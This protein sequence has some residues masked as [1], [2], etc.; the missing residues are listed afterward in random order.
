MVSDRASC[1]CLWPAESTYL[2]GFVCYQQRQVIPFPNAGMRDR[3]M[4]KPL[5]WDRIIAHPIVGKNPVGCYSAHSAIT[6]I[7]EDYQ[8]EPASQAQY[9]VYCMGDFSPFFSGAFMRWR[10]HEDQKVDPCF[11]FLG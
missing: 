3:A 6:S 2:L 5:I 8:I 1:R 7:A 9:S 10:I 11:K 4:I